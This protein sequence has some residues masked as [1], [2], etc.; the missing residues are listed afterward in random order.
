[1]VHSV[2]CITWDEPNK[3]WIS[4]CTVKPTSSS[5]Q[6]ICNCKQHNPVTV[7]YYNVLVQP[8]Q[9]LEIKYKILYVDNALIVFLVI[10]TLILFI[11]LF[12]WA[13]MED[14]SDRL[15][16]TVSFLVDNYPQ[17]DYCYLVIVH[18]GWKIEAGTTSNVTIELEGTQATSLPHILK[19]WTREVLSTGGQDWF[20]IKTIKPLGEI[21]CLHVWTDYSGSRPSWYCS[22]IIVQD[23][24]VLWLFQFLIY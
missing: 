23:V 7:A 8:Q 3:S 18:T 20:V 13:M 12:K 14:R 6:I 5:S 9:L 1:M 17:C 21:Y 16:R 24:K 22:K 19:D 10:F 15:K 2:Q 11:G 4:N